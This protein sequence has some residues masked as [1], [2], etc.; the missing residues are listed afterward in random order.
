MSSATSNLI[1]DTDPLPINQEGLIVFHH[2]EAD[3]RERL[4]PATIVAVEGALG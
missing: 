2:V 1:P 3:Y 4:D